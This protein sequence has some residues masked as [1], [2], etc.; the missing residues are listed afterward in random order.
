[1]SLAEIQERLLGATDEEL[2]GIAETVRHLQDMDIVPTAGRTGSRSRRSGTAATTPN[3]TLSQTWCTASA[4]VTV[5]P[6][7]LDGATRAPDDADMA[8]LTAAAAP[9][10]DAIDRLGLSP[11]KERR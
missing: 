11:R 4:S 3:L 5:S 2:A 8:E 9:L 7:L 1:M 10:L 6:S